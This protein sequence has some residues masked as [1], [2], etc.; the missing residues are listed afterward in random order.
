MK[1]LKIVS[2]SLLLLIFLYWTG[3]SSEDHSP[4]WYKGNLHTHTTN[5]DGDTEAETVIQWYKT[6]GYNFL[7]ITDHNFIT[8]VDDYKEMFE[9]DFILISGNEI[10]DGLDQTPVHILA[11]GLYDEQV[12][13]TG[14]QDIQSTLQNN[15]DSIRGAN[16]VPVL[17]HPNFGWAFGAE[18]M[19]K[20]RNCALFEVL[21]A[22]PSVNNSG[23]EGRPST[24]EMWDQTLSSG[25]IIYGIGTDDMHKIATY[26]GKSW[27]MVRAEEL[28][29]GAILSA[30]E[31]GDF[32]V[33]TGVSLKDIIISESYIQI[34]L[35]EDGSEKYTTSFI[36][37]NGLILKESR[38]LNPRYEFTGKEH[39]V[40][41][42]IFDSRGKLA[43]TQPVFPHH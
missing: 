7:A 37:D 34:Y 36:G 31:K 17:A 23:G 28:S 24:E 14:G 32:Y 43:L 5:S 22:H 20:I 26:P 35:D 38:S 41:I 4:L 39:Y 29:E 9:N 40:R 25:K 11:L 18:E 42:R 16:A 13:P 3:C 21:N 33:S 1:N 27:V 30:L 15:V 2:I 8:R 6:H 10:S 19:K 12:L